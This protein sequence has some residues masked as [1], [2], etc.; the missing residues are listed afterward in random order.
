MKTAMHYLVAAVAAPSASVL[1]REIPYDKIE[2]KTGKV[3][4]NLAEV[5]SPARIATARPHPTPNAAASRGNTLGRWFGF[6]AEPEPA[7]VL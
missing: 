6:R 2:I 7:N 1:A 4:P 5:Y 3:A